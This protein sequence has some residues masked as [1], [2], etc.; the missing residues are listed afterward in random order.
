[1][2]FVFYSELVSRLGVNVDVTIKEPTLSLAYEY[3]GMPL[4]FL[5]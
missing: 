2:T 5:L 1:M 3:A 4:L